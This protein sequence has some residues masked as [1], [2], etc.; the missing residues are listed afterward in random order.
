MQSKKNKK[1]K[2]GFIFSQF[3][4][5]FLS[6]RMVKRPTTTIATNKPAIA[7]R[8]YRSAIESGCVGCGEAVAGAVSTAKEVCADE[9]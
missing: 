8:K 1:G 7:G 3:Y 4:G 5:F 6:I 9:P 2:F